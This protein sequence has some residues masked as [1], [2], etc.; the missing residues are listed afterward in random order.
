MKRNWLR[1]AAAGVLMTAA[2]TASA[3]VSLLLDQGG[4]LLGA[5]GVAVNGALYDVTFQD[6]ACFGLYGLCNGPDAFVFDT[7][8][9]ATAATNALVNQVFIDVPAGNFDTDPGKTNGIGAGSNYSSVNTPFSVSS[10]RLNIVSFQNAINDAEDIV[11]TTYLGSTLTNLAQFSGDTFAVWSP[12]AP[13]PEP[14]ESVL[15][16]LGLVSLGV[17]LRRKTR[18]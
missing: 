2:G 7:E 1:K 15:L 14:A 3:D 18:H 13:V 16:A 11:F 17:M 4:K 10:G 5:T 6:G 12:A 9:D 8:A